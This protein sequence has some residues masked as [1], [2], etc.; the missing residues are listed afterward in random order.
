MIQLDLFQ[1][2]ISNTQVL[3]ELNHVK[4]LARTT[5][6]SATKVRK[7]IFARHGELAKMYLDLSSRLEIIERNLC[8]GDN[9]YSHTP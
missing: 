9:E 6:E 2:E 8:R 1:E 3:R 7:G 5:S 4:E